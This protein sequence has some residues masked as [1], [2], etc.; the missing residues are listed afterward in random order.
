[1]PRLLI[2]RPLPG[3]VAERLM[4]LGHAVD[5]I[6]G[7]APP[8]RE[9]LLEAARAKPYEAVVVTLTERVDAELLDALPGVRLVASYNVGHDNID[10][11][12]A[13]RRGIAVTHAEGSFETSI[14]EHAVGLMLGLTARIAEGDALVRAGRFNGWSPA[15]LLGRD[16]SGATVGIVGAGRIGS[17]CARMLATA[18]K[19]RILYH[20]PERNASLEESCGAVRVELDELMA[21]ADIVSVHVPLLPE[22]RHLIDARR[23]ALMRPGSYLVNTARGAVVDEAALVAA[24]QSGAIAGAGLDVFEHEPDLAPGL[25]GLANVILTPHAASARG[26][27]R[28]EMGDQVV[29]VVEAFFSG[30][31]PPG[32]VR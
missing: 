24:L 7:E 3:D 31:T 10:V 1:M 32:L 14:A 16:L 21:A 23:L 18:F 26:A 6:P 2:T 9:T 27:A 22:T 28:A 20:D 13:A 30:A 4:A 15:G 19:A 11:A 29:A 25:A 12:E 5:V 8:T 17:E